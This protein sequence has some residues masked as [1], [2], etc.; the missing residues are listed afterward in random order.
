MASQEERDTALFEA[1]KG[2]KVR[3]VQRFIEGGLSVDALVAVLDW[4]LRNARVEIIAVLRAEVDRLLI[5]AALSGDRSTV[6]RLKPY[7]SAGAVKKAEEI[8]NE[9]AVPPEPERGGK[10]P[11]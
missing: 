6:D 7:A 11:K 9:A 2:G 3:A 4:A 10:G 5:E 8:L 1:V